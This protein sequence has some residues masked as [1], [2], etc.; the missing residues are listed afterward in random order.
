M[1]SG[2]RYNMWRGIAEEGDAYAGQE[3]NPA[4]R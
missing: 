1:A 2:E 3:D 4:G